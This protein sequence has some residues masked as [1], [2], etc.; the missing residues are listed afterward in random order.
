MLMGIHIAYVSYP[1]LAEYVRRKFIYS[2]YMTDDGNVV[3][4]ITII[5]YETNPSSLRVI[6]VDRETP[7][8]L[9]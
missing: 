8:L 3:M 5:K 6:H 9:L 4:H 7:S 2:C 1:L